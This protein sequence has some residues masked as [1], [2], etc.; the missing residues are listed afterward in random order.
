M[1][2]FIIEG[3]HPLQGTIRASGNKNAALKLLPACLMT[4]EP[5][6]LH[7]IPDIEDVRVALLLLQDLGAEVT[8]L[9]GGSWRIHAAEIRKTEMD[10]LLASRIRASVVFSGPLLARMGEITLPLPGRRRHWRASTR[11]PR[12]RPAGAGRDG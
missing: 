1:S 2:Q 10:P 12:P 9:G 11:Y 5:I 4:S 3:G 7:N 6:T 8:D